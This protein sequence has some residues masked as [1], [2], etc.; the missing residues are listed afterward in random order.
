[1]KAKRSLQRILALGS[2]GLF[3]VT[4]S[5]DATCPTTTTG[6]SQTGTK[7]QEFATTGGAGVVYDPTQAG[8]TLGKAGGIFGAKFF[9]ATGNPHVACPADFDGDGW[10][11]FVGITVDG[12]ELAWYRNRT[13]VNQDADI[14]AG[15][16][17]W[18]NTSYITTPRFDKVGYIEKTGTAT[19]PWATGDGA[20]AMGCGDF[21]GDGKQ[22]F[23]VI[24]E[25]GNDSGRPYR[26]DMFIGKGDGTFQPRYQLTSGGSTDSYRDTFRDQWWDSMPFVV[27]YNSDG[28]LDFLW[29]AEDP[30]ATDKGYIQVYYNVG[31]AGYTASAAKPTFTAGP[32]ILDALSIG[33]AGASA[34]SYLDFTGDGVK[35]L[36]MTGVKSKPIRT[37]TGISG[38]GFSSTYLS[39]NDSGW[40]GTGAQILVGADFNLD[41]KNDLVLGT[42]NATG[43]SPGQVLYWANTGGSTH[44]G[45]TPST[46]I[47]TET[48][49]DFDAGFGFD[50]D[51]DP[52]HTRDFMFADGN[53]AG[54]AVFANRVQNTYVACGD[55]TSG[56]LDLGPLASSDMIVTS[57]RLTPSQSLPAGTSVTYYMSNEDPPNWQL[58][59][60]CVDDPASVCVTFPNATGRTIR[61]KATMCSNT[62][63][64]STPVIT[65][66]N[67]KF[68]YTKAEQ[69]FRSGV[70]VD[71]EVAYM[72]AFQVPG[73]KGHLYA[74]N[75][76]LSSTYWDA[77]VKLD[78]MSDSSRR[79]Y[80]TASDGK[81]RLDFTTAAASNAQLQTMLTAPTTAA[82]S[83]LVT[84]QR[85]ARF[86]ISS[87][88]RLGSIR[89][90]TPAVM[91][92]PIRPYYYSQLTVTE[93]GKVDAYIA[94]QKTRTTLVLFGS[95]DGAIHAIVS[96]PTTPAATTNGVESWAFIPS[97]VASGFTT[98]Q[99]L[100]TPLNYPDGSPTLAD[101]KIGTA[102]RTVMVAGLGDGGKGYVALDV[103]DSVASGPTPLW[104]YVPGESEAGN[105]SAKPV[106]IR[107]KIGT[108]ERFLAVL[109]TGVASDN[110]TAPW[111]KGRI[112]EAVD[113]ATGV[114]A[115]RFKA[116]CPVT[117]DL[118]AFETDDEAEDGSPT[119]DGYVDRVVF[120][121]MCGN[122]YK[123]N[124]AVDLPG[125]GSTQGWTTGLGSVSTSTTDPAGHAIK[126]LFSVK[127]TAGALG[128]ERP[129]AGT[130]AARPDETG[131]MTL[132]LG[133]GGI[134]SY[135][136]TKQNAFY[137]VY[138]DTGE[139]RDSTLGSCSPSTHMC[140]K[141][142]GG[143]VVSDTQVLVTRSVDPPIATSGCNLGSASIVGFGLSSLSSQ[144][145]VATTSSIVSSLFGANGALYSTTLQGKAVRIGTPTSSDGGS[146]TPEDTSKPVGR[147]SWRQV[148]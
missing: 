9:A 62:S 14:L 13:K 95:L 131:R 122:L 57:A 127:S 121:D 84:W 43:G 144:F 77:A 86:G 139:I 65:G 56:V 7:L 63:R 91:S 41:G 136:V 142:Y 111:T 129:I 138:L 98:D 64:S 48:F 100:T 20:F 148:M 119:I 81:T 126:A 97:R 116:A 55:V 23:F 61:W 1:V 28:K 143:A 79:I 36:A 102:Y 78:A 88:S 120:A 32:K 53:G 42:D 125:T 2:L 15:T 93:K 69:H 44:V 137:A 106:I 108:V 74:A 17:N 109:A 141:F 12:T 71:R 133:T 85:G 45:H 75:A 118:A 4:A 29:P 130:I 73:D 33:N 8:L 5:G 114:R 27:D 92:P 35:D 68:T 72:G 105:A 40:T 70:V 96:D 50:Y 76:T 37:Y 46:Q 22:D 89:S 47:I 25:V 83:A 52:D 24:L 16:L 113:I 11:D 31:S 107:V 59:L 135:D 54:Y 99:A 94:A 3:A 80:T 34:V 6:T 82:A 49:S 103:T 90:S 146:E 10:T 123:I 38:G 51:N 104:D 112:V 19:P 67:L 87:K 30:S 128:A 145:V 26:A 140:E 58:A 117:T 39:S 115:W 147:R 18:N 134:E 21:S 101:V 110:P 60:P 132:F 124:P 66:V